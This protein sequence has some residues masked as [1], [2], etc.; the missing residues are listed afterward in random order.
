M[1]KRLVILNSN[2]FGK[3]I[4]RLDDCDSIQL[5]GPNN[6]GKST[7]IFTLNFLFIIDGKKM[8]FVDN[9][10]EK[11][12]HLLIQTN[13]D[14]LKQS[15][16]LINDLLP[17]IERIRT[18]SLIITGWI[19][20]LKNPYKITPPKLLKTDKDN[21][22]S[23]KIYYNT[24]EYFE[25]FVD[26]EEVIIEEDTDEEERW[27]FN[28]S[29]YKKKLIEKLPL[30]NFF[31]WCNEQL[32][33]EKSEIT[34]EKIFALTGLLFEEDLEISYSTQNEIIKI[35]TKTANLNVPKLKISQNG[36]S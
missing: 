14:L 36:I 28:K 17:L 4:V 5:V 23:N 27:L 34:N 15:K 13:D 8:T 30:E 18:E 24:K 29:L 35:K 6:I 11:L 3:A 16:I 25:Q 26:I 31:D 12:Y 7:L 20:F 21:P 10:T 1:L 22:Y 19:E 9:R 32:L 33:I 2:T